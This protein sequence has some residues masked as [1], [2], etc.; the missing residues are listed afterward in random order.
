MAKGQK[1]SIIA[2][3]QCGWCKKALIMLVENL[4]DVELFVHDIRSPELWEEVRKYNWESIPC[5]WQGG[6]FIGGYGELVKHLDESK[7]GTTPETPEEEAKPE[8]LA[9]KEQ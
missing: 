2:S 9:Q 5:I 3:P 8:E 1:Y 4:K 7:Q 6:K